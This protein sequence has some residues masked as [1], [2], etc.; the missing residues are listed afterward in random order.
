LDIRGNLEQLVAYSQTRH[1]DNYIFSG[2]WTN[3]PPYEIKKGMVSFTSERYNEIDNPNYIEA[4]LAQNRPTPN[5]SYV[6]NVPIDP[7]DRDTWTVF[8]PAEPIKIPLWDN[9]YLNTSIN[10]YNDAVYPEAQRI[11]PGSFQLLNDYGL[12][13]KPEK[14]KDFP[15]LNEVAASTHPDYNKADYEVD[16]E[17]G[18][19]IL[20][21][22]KAKA[23][24][25]DNTGNLKDAGPNSDN[26][27]PE[28]SFDYVY[29]N[30]K[31]MS[32]EI[33][34]EIDTGITVK[35]NSNP[36]A[37]FGKDG[38]GET[39]AFK[40]LIHLMQGLWYNDQS[41]IAEGI[42]TIDVAHKRVLAEQTIIG[43]KQSRL[44]S[45]YNR[46]L[47]LSINETEALGD[48]V[49]VDYTEALTKF[50]E[51]DLVYNAS[52]YAA[53]VMLRRT[54]MDYL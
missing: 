13:E 33:Y 41:Q 21:S 27:P 48:I 20:I 32:G 54:L 23:A 9:A 42:D 45:V 36:S 43:G 18:V 47:D 50:N 4:M 19:L 14:V 30:P 8:E 25:Y 26:K 29:C 10:N 16:Y 6:P 24:F 31:D 34:R 11:I 1:K 3:M 52:L 40:E 53:S 49:S 22:D 7:D 44:D 2:K 39:D 51:A 15:P 17:N 46:N 35:I 38:R 5:P 28:L 37:M 12:V